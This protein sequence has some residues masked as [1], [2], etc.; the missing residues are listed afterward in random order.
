MADRVEHAFLPAAER[1]IPDGT[2]VLA[3][4]SG[5]ADSVALL[6][7]LHRLAGRRA[8]DVQVAHLDHGL[9]PG[10]RADRRFVEQLARRLELPL[11]AARREV[12]ALR[13]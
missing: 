5:G 1:L 7:L 8:L 10:S 13:R 9:R 3:A 4:V 12:S 6:H 2:R 11:I